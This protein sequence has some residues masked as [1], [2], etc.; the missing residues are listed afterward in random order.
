[1]FVQNPLR[2]IYELNSWNEKVRHQSF[3]Y[4]KYL[5]ISVIKRSV[6]APVG[7]SELETNKRRHPCYKFIDLN[8]GMFLRSRKKLQK[9]DISVLKIIVINGVPIVD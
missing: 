4:A 8:W 1:M 6:F 9:L 5:S 7:G 2:I 3:N